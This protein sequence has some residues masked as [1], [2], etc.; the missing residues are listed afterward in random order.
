MSGDA[1]H[2]RPQPQDDANE[3]F[4][5]TVPQ[6]YFDRIYAGSL[7]PWQFETSDYERQKYRA[8]LDA[9]SCPRYRRVLEVG[10]SIG[11]LTQALA[12]RCDGLLAVDIA[13]RAL[14]VARRR[15]AADTHVAFRRM[16][17]PD[18]LPD[19]RFDLVVLSEV[20][21]YWSAAD[22]SRVL[23]FSATALE[24]DGT[25]ELVH[26]VIAKGDYPLTGDEVHARAIAHLC[27]ELIHDDR[28]LPYRLTVLRRI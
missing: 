8:T 1:D 17:L 25:L 9:L 5:E 15:C 10:C 16:T 22:L 13:E 6:A 21:Y 18:E 2:K 20:G 23:D 19:G 24:P 14:D 7:D 3:R 26:W 4:T 12:A 11:V 27:F 28:P